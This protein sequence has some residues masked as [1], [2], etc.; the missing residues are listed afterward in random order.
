MSNNKF[1]NFDISSRILEHDANK[2]EIKLEYNLEDLV[3]TNNYKIETYFFIPYELK[4]NKS[5]YTKE[6][7][8]ADTKNYIRFMNP[9]YSLKQI[10]DPT[11]KQS[12]LYSLCSIAEKYKK[13]EDIE[14]IIKELKL[15]GT[16]VRARLRDWR[17]FVKHNL[18]QSKNLKKKL[19]DFKG[20]M[21]NCQKVLEKFRKLQE[22]YIKSIEDKQ[23]NQYFQIVEEF[24][25][26]MIE[27]RL[28]QVFILIEEKNKNSPNNGH[29]LNKIKKELKIFLKQ[30]RAIRK[31]K[32]FKLIL[33]DTKK[34]KEKYLY[35]FSRYKKIVSS[36]LY[37]DIS[38]GKKNTTYGHIIAAWAAFFSAALNSYIAIYIFK[39]YAAN[40]IFFITLMALLYV[41]KDRV[42]NILK[43]IVGTKAL[44]R[45]PDSFTSIK[46]TSEKKIIKLGEIREKV[47][48]PSVSQINSE[49]L[50][51]KD[52]SSE[53]PQSSLEKILVYQKEINIKTSLIKKYY[54]RTTNLTDIM[55][56]NLNKFLVNMGNPTK[57]IYYYNQLSGK[58]K[59]TKGDRVYQLGL[60]IRYT[61]LAKRRKKILHYEHYNI[62]CTKL[63]IKRVEF[64]KKA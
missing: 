46:D 55:R 18:K 53:S 25:S 4:I 57:S 19:T 34:G 37:L 8:Y 43:L 42:K 5:T 30:E 54:S 47:F 28:T 15:T 23:V 29:E 60:I 41:F 31:I 33:E 56:L 61:K 58:L 32:K 11:F 39:T 51:I 24:L 36:V 59:R 49:V 3:K 22:I 64:V 48:F 35:W 52:K 26:N 21:E 7:F 44:S 62:I 17:I 45:F 13:E 27:E 10:T 9:F 14:Q 63:G 38:R 50:K 2:L 16:M 6:D 40:T 1:K 20:R 12:P